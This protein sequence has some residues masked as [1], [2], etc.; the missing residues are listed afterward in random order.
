MDD[1]IHSAPPDA[2]HSCSDESNCDRDT[3]D[4]I[5][6][7]G[8]EARQKGKRLLDNPYRMGCEQREEWAAGWSAT[9]EIDD[10]DDE[11]NTGYEKN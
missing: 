4:A 10:E 8:V 6:Q 7:A 5:L 3:L 2:F 11:P 1:L 9:V